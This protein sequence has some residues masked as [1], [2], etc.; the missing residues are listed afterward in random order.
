MRT[1]FVFLLALS[2]VSIASPAR[3]GGPDATHDATHVETI[4]GIRHAELPP[5]ENLGQLSCRGLNR[6][7]ALPKLLTGRYGTP[8]FIFAPNPAM[9]GHTAYSYVRPLMTLEPTAIWLAMPV[10]TQ[11]GAVDIPL[12]QLVLTNRAYEDSLIFIAWEHGFL[13]QFAK[14]LVKAYGG[15]PSTVPGWPGNDFDSIYVVR[16]TRRGDK[17]SVSFQHDHEDLTNRLSDTCPGF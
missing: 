1:F 17:T 9:K 7:M 15:D 4:V 16:L 13:D 5:G 10:N 2:W 6:A 8:H 3:A 14:N 12:L 11:I